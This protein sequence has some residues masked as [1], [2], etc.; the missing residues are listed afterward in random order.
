MPYGNYVIKGQ[1]C[2]DGK[3]EILYGSVSDR[4]FM[5]SGILG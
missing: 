2:S 1:L 4:L 3:P 5:G